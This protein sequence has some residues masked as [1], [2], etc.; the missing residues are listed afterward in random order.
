[1]AIII[2]IIIIITTATTN[3]NNKMDEVCRAVIDSC[4]LLD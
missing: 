1:V 2:I 3:N 4:G